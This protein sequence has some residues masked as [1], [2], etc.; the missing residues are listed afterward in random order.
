[1]SEKEPIVIYDYSEDW[2]ILFVDLARRLR[3]SLGPVALRIDHI[4][5][6]SIPGLAAKPIVDIQISVASLEP[7]DP[8][9]VPLEALGFA[10]RRDNPDRNKRY[11]REKPGTRRTHIHV[12]RAG[13][14]R[15][16][17][18]LLFRDYLRGHPNDRK[19][20]EAVKRELAK[21]YRNDRVRYTDGKSDI[22]WEMMVR[23]DRW[24]RET[25]WEAGPSDA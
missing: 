24:A 23:A 8:F 1:M 12:V 22:L 15:E 5:S 4:G 21:E 11:F 17:F 25:G 7:V 13:S 20:Y 2:P 9:R 19:E 10:W 16:Q 3:E 6:S 18:A 14:W